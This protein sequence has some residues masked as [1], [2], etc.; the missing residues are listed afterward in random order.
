MGRYLDPKCRLC[1]REGEK[2]FL[3]GLKCFTEKCSFSRRPYPPGVHG[4][5]QSKPSYYAL[6]LREKQKVKRMYGMFE[7]QFKRFFKLAAKSKE[8]TGR[9][10]LELL[11]R[12]LDNVVY[13]ALFA[14]SRTEARQIVRHGFV[15]IGGR[16]VNIPSYIVKE[17]EEIYIKAKEDMIKR[18]RENM[19]VNSKYRSV[20]TWIEVDKENLKIVIEK[21]PAK[22]DL[23]VTVNEQ[24]IVELYSK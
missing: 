13:R 18:I 1:R 21:L 9:K 3:K 16:R 7:S 8:P 19:E 4:K 2:L 14:T 5:K 12:R 17:K 15:F 24:L 23:T 22:E 6:Q 11:E 10:L 20:P